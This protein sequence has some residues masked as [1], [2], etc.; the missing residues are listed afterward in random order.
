MTFQE[1]STVLTL[2]IWIDRQEQFKSRSDFFN[3]SSLMWVYIVM[4]R[5]EMDKTP[6][7]SKIDSS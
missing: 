3:R 5:T 6:D 4:D 2:N 7:I 1:Q